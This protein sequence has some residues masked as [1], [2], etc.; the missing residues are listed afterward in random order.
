MTGENW[1]G[2]LMKRW[3]IGTEHDNGWERQ[4]W[5]GIET[6]NCHT[7]SC[8]SIWNDLNIWARKWNVISTKQT[9]NGEWQSRHENAR[10]RQE[11]CEPYMFFAIRDN[12]R[13]CLDWCNF[14]PRGIDF[15]CK[16]YS[17]MLLDG[18]T[19]QLFY[20]YLPNFTINVI[21]LIGTTISRLNL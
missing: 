10:S 5:R 9:S 13:W 17:I 11:K 21:C 19:L 2:T 3:I 14:T 15:G 20:S 8:F 18:L 12:L 7:P 6:R 4:A 1:I 16:F